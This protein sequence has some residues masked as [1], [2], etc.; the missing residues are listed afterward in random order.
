V[1]RTPDPALSTAAMEAVNRWEFRPTHLDGQPIDTHM[2]V[3]VNF[4]AA[5]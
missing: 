2:T 5:K 3:T 4:V 1:L